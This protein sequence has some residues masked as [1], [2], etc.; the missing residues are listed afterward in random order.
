MSVLIAV[1]SLITHFVLPSLIY[2]D[3][4]WQR[5]SYI[6]DFNVSLHRDPRINITWSWKVNISATPNLHQAFVHNLSYSHLRSFLSFNFSS[7]SVL[8]SLVSDRF[9]WQLSHQFLRAEVV[10]AWGFF[11]WLKI[12]ILCPHQPTKEMFLLDPKM[13]SLAFRIHCKTM[14]NILFF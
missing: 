10:V 9:K 12:Q 11:P 7:A 14:L 4:A 13:S 8:E 5:G 3:F 6:Q 1:F 2:N